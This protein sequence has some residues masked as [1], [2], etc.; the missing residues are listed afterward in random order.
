ML[1]ADL[2]DVA[3]RPREEAAPP[4]GYDLAGWVGRKR[5]V[6]CRYRRGRASANR[7]RRRCLPRFGTGAVN[8]SM[9]IVTVNS[10]RGCRP[11]TG[12][13]AGAGGHLDEGVGATLLHGSTDT[14]P[15]IL[16][17]NWVP[18]RSSSVL[19]ISNPIGS[20]TPLITPSPPPRRR[21]QVSTLA[22]GVG[23]TIGGV[24]VGALFPVLDAPVSDAE[25]R[26]PAQIDQALLGVGEVGI[27]PLPVAGSDEV[28]V[29]PRDLP[30]DGRRHRCAASPE[31]HGHGASIGEVTAPQV[32]FPGQA[33]T[34]GLR[35]VAGPQLAAV[36]HPDQPTHAPPAV[37]TGDPRRPRRR[38]QGRRGYRRRR[39]RARRHR[40]ESFEQSLNHDPSYRT[41]VRKTNPA[42]EIPSPERPLPGSA[43][44][45]TAW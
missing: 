21:R 16:Q 6:R 36:P 35:A 22:H 39:R 23:I 14:V 28:D 29:G 31:G 34:G 2:D 27:A 19:K 10:G 17:P 42:P 20:N 40:I 18:R 4:G 45:T 41:Y 8:G 30:G 37:S 15:Q 25:E 44:K 1:V 38:A 33:G 11:S 24:T 13:I 43:P 5:C 32:R 3:Q 7:G 9:P 26:C 12:A